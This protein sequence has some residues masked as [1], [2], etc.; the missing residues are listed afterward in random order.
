MSDH[1]TQDVCTPNHSCGAHGPNH[2][3][4]RDCGH[5][6]VRHGDHTDYVVNDHRHHSHGAHC[7]DHG[8]IQA[9]FG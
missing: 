8:R 2:Q 9:S 1:S 4:G 3:H 7:D 6:S 5:T